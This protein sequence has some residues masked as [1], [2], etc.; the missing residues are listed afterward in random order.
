MDLTAPPDWRCIDLISD[1]H[2]HPGDPATFAAWS[3]YL[4]GTPADAVLIL[5]DL[6]E[7]WVGDDVLATPPPF[8]MACVRALQSAGQRLALFIMHGNRDFLMGPALMAAC[9]ATALADPS[10]LVFGGQRWLLAHGD[11]LCLDDVAYQQFRQQVRSPA[12][13]GTF[14]ARP[15]A[16]RQALARA[17]RAESEARKQGNMPYADVDTGAALAA[18]AKL[19]SETLVHGHTHKPQTH[20]LDHHKTRVV[21]SDWDLQ[22]QPPRAEVLRLRMLPAGGVEMQRLPAAQAGSAQPRSLSA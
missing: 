14:L 15:L 6:F 13:Q 18:L 2:L 16:E 17:M 21:L 12:W 9:H 8:E 4:S 5:G 7:V 20:T 11:A 10:A 3:A 1:V 19:Q 22:A